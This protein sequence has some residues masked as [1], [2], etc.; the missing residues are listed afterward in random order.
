MLTDRK[1]AKFL[2]IASFPVNNAAI[3]LKMSKPQISKIVQSDGFL[4]K[5]FG[6]PI[7][8]NVLTPL[9]KSVLMSLGL[10]AAALAAD[11]GIQKN[12]LGLAPDLMILEPLLWESKH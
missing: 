10:I 2:E 12:I 7:A 9:T 3:N 4:G 1:V 5:L 11:I 8:R 6:P